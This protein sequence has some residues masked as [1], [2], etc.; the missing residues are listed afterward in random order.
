MFQQEKALGNHLFQLE[1]LFYGTT[2]KHLRKEDL[3]N[4]EIPIPSL[5][6]QQDIVGQCDHN[7]NLVMSYKKQIET[8]ERKNPFE[9][10]LHALVNI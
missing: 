4:I 7:N 2:I 8:I 1:D 3:E 6:V 10:V 9:D 5:E